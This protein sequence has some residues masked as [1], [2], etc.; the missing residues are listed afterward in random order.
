MAGGGSL[1]QSLTVAPLLSLTPGCWRLFVVNPS[2]RS[3]W[4]FGLTGAKQAPASVLRGSKQRQD[5]QAADQIAP[6]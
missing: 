6:I 5:Q 4:A 3:R 2:R 1:K